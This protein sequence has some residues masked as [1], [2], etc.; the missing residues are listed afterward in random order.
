MQRLL[1]SLAVLL[2]VLFGLYMAI[3]YQPGDNG[4]DVAQGDAEVLIGGP[5]SL[6][7]DQGDTVTDQTYRGKILVIYFGFTYCPDICPTELQKISF[8]LD[9]LSETERAKL[10]TLFI[11]VDPERDT[12]EQ[13]ALYLQNFHP[14]ITG[15]TGTID[16]V[17]AA[18]SVYRIYMQKVA[19][20]TSS[21]D[22]TMDHS[23]LIYVMDGENHYITHFTGRATADKIAAKLKDML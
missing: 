1:I 13:L 20:E 11:T 18:A 9:Q 22:Y 16:Q 2:A 7:N 6:V 15:L 10:A 5:F 17:K 8:A 19:D 12:P 23:N 4:G 21:A 3:T 14:D